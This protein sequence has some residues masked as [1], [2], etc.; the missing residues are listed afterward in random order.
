MSFLRFVGR[1]CLFLVNCAIPVTAQNIPTLPPPPRTAAIVVG[2][3][4][5]PSAPQSPP[6]GQTRPG[7]AVQIDADEQRRAGDTLYAD[8]YVVIEYDGARLQADHVAYDEKSGAARAEGNV[9]Y[10]PQ[11]NQ[12]LTARRAELDIRRKTG[13]FYDVTGYTDQTADGGLLEFAAAR[14]ERV[15]RDTYILYDAKLTSCCEDAVPLWT[16]TARQARIRVNDYASARNAAFRVKGAPIVPLPY[17]A[18]PLDRRERKS[19]FLP[20]TTGNNT[21]QGRVLGVGY[22]QTLGDSADL[23]VQGDIYSAR[24]LGF[25]ATLRVALAEDSYLRLGSYSVADRL[26]GQPGVN[27]S[28]TLFF[29]KAINR[30]ANGFVGAAD[31]N[32]TSSFDFRA[33]FGNTIEDAFNPES[34]I[35]LHLTKQTPTFDFRALYENRTTRVNIPQGELGSTLVEFSIRKSPSLNFD[36]LP[37]RLGRFA[38]ATWYAGGEASLAGLRRTETRADASQQTFAT[39]EFVQRLDAAPRLT[40]R[41]RDFGGWSVTPMLGFRATYYG[42][43]FD[44]E[45]T[46][47]PRPP[48]AFGLAPPPTVLP[49]GAR[50]GTAGESLF[51]RFAD[52]SLEV[53]PPA[54]GRAFHAKDGSPR[55]KH[56]IESS[57]IYRRV[58]GIDDFPRILRFDALDVFANTNELEYSVVNRLLTPVRDETGQTRQAREA[59]SL[60]I[61]QKYFFDPTFGGALTPGQ[62]NQIAP[63]LTFSGFAY[64]GIGRR[65]SPIN[66]KLRLTPQQSFAADARIDFDPSLGGVRSFGFTGGIYRRRFQLSQTW[67]YSQPRRLADG[68]PEPGTFTGSQSF[69]NVALGDPTRG[70]FGSAAVAY[71]FSRSPN[72]ATSRLQR[73][74]L[75]FTSFSL[76]YAF[77]CATVQVNY[78][79]VNLGVASA[80][81]LTFSFALRGLGTF[82]A[83][84]DQASGNRIRNL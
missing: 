64:G 49:I 54:L 65:F 70:V 14:V 21:L 47:T 44:P 81:R 33:I 37:T 42:A 52:F 7:A 29:A 73:K 82:G 16:V 80:G 5:A 4:G 78:A 23:T 76:G 79:S 10:D 31:I 41:L 3:P 48:L 57:V 36:W 27:Q 59:L 12:R 9:I 22:Y 66:V 43:T 2:P 63:L 46:L 17:I 84:Q 26:F 6:P 38:G 71:D 32:Y 28:G 35:I 60:T 40:A 50:L 34:K 75:I 11:P 67:Y 19:G 8:G 13:V 18:L 53:R 69:T 62:R 25:G 55:F 61:S 74:G 15:A 83:Q 58:A 20:P 1:A 77:R 39:P 72:P 56:I 45:T 30:F 51:R 24:G 68:Q